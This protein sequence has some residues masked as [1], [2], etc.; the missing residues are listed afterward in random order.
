MSFKIYGITDF[1]ILGICYDEKKSDAVLL[2][3]TEALH[4]VKVK[5]QAFIS[6]AVYFC[7]RFSSCGRR[8]ING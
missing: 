8:S 1:K 6:I 4:I 2:L 3:Q 7:T 5:V